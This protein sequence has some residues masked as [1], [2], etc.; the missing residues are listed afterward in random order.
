MLSGTSRRKRSLRHG[1]QTGPMC[2][3]VARAAEG[4]RQWVARAGEQV[5]QRLPPAVNVADGEEA[6]VAGA[7]AEAGDDRIF[8][9]LVLL[10]AEALSLS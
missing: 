2:R 3:G 6:E 7:Q 10:C 9:S 8:N 4:L 5:V 1:W